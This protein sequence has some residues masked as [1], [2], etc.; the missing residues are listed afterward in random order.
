M[1]SITLLNMWWLCM[2][3]DNEILN[4]QKNI[5]KILPLECEPVYV[6]QFI[7]FYYVLCNLFITKMFCAILIQNYVH[8][9]FFPFGLLFVHDSYEMSKLA[10]KKIYEMSKQGDRWHFKSIFL[11]RSPALACILSFLKWY[12]FFL[13][14][15]L[16]SCVKMKNLPIDFLWWGRGSMELWGWVRS[17]SETAA[18]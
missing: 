9:M 15:L 3:K 10:S 2:S 6:Y 17:D 4:P 14:L 5:K 13:H 12:F 11:T 16:V 1:Y 7:L 8:A 18:T